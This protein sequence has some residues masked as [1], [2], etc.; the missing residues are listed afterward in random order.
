MMLLLLVLLAVCAVFAG[1]D[2]WYFVRAF[3]LVA[4]EKRRLNRLKKLGKL[5]ETAAKNLLNVHSTE[6]IVLP[7]DL[8]F[9]MHM[10]NSKYL[11]E[12]DFGRFRMFYR[13]GMWDALERRSSSVVAAAITIRYRRSLHLFQRFA[14]KT[15]IVHWS[16]N[17]LYVEQRI[18]DASSTFV[19]AVA[20][21]KMVFLG[22]SV[23]D[24]IGDICDKTVSPPPTDELRQWI[25]YNR[26]S[27]EKLRRQVGKDGEKKN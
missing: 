17:N 13:T 11:R 19:Q 24:V 10:N 23:D 9:M 5:K 6:G 27:S 2:V 4:T 26:L 3:V 25:E 16:T 18:E 21:V 8:D 7:S 1:T 22:A 12:C 14:I 20:L 15:R